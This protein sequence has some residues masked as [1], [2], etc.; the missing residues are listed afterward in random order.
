MREM[1]DMVVATR[2]NRDQVIEA[3]RRKVGKKNITAESREGG[4]QA[5]RRVLFLF[6]AGS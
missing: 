2:L 5:R 1:A 4:G 3:V 6:A